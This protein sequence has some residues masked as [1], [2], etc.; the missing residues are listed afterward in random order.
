M[1]RSAEDGS[2]RAVGAWWTFV[3][4]RD[5]ENVFSAVWLLLPCLEHRAA[6]RRSPET[7]SGFRCPPSPG[8]ERRGL[9]PPP[10]SPPFSPPTLSCWASDPPLPVTCLELTCVQPCTF[11]VCTCHLVV[12]RVTARPAGPS[13]TQCSD[14]G[15]DPGTP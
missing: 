13:V 10:S 5:A 9:S 6:F 14:P 2:A 12:S 7:V 1:P 3:A 8:S 11:L 15:S 4:W